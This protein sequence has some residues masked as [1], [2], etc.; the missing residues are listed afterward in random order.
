MGTTDEETDA[1]PAPAAEPG[2]EAVDTFAERLFT[3]TLG[4]I[5]VLAVHVGDRLGWYRALA[6]AGPLTSTALAER[7]GTHE[8]YA[9]EWLEQQAASG[10]LA[11]EDP[12]A[13]PA[14]VADPADVARERRYALPAAHAEVLTDGSSLAYSAPLARFVGAV[15]PQLPHLLD[16]YRAGGGVSW[17]QLGDDAREA[18]ADV[19]R[20][21]FEHRL[22]PTLAGLPEVHDV[23]SRP[24]ARVVDVGCGFGW[25]T[26]AL[27]QAYP[28]AVVR[29]ID[30]D[31]PSVEAARAAAAAAGLAD[32][33]T[34]HHADAAELHLAEPCD[35]A[36]AF[37]CVHDLPR[38]VAVLDAVRRAVRPDGVVVVMDEAVADEF[39]APADDVDRIMYGY[40]L[41][42]C[43]P[44]GM[45]TQPSAGTGT[46][47]RPATLRR[48]ALEAGFA[49]VEALPVDDFAFF[50][51]YRLVL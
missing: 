30:V 49:G 27:A 23:L 14:L 48:Y 11:A 31:R 25:S 3:A 36:F 35:A 28:D 43:L 21:W 39:A 37:E 34:F 41:F 13:G 45:S 26:L 8:R 5:D 7:T 20:P 22:A 6:D 47:M 9:R 46:V 15:G 44:D 42:V 29:G 50:R 18:Q 16:A 17:D 2:R 1:A 4:A 51:F 38:P 40:S 19:N 10:I 32:R 33:V 24:G 12:A